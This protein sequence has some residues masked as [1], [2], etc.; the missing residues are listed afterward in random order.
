[1][2]GSPTATNGNT[3]NVFRT[4]DGV[5]FLDLEA[6]AKCTNVL[7]AAAVEL[8]K[9]CRWAARDARAAAAGDS[10]SPAGRKITSEDLLVC[11]VDIFG[12][13][14]GDQL[15]QIV[16]RTKG[17]PMQWFHRRRNQIHKSQHPEEV[18]KYDIADTLEQ[19]LSEADLPGT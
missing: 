3:G 17:R 18:T 6:E 15:E 8:A 12:C 2:A 16:R 11:V 19:L 7:D 1:M 13:D 4:P 10:R 14:R 9:L 5:F